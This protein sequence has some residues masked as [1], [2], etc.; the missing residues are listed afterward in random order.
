[1]FEYVDFLKSLLNEL[2]N[3]YFVYKITK[4]TVQFSIRKFQQKNN[5]EE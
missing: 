1:M 3:I 4:K 2:K 5:N